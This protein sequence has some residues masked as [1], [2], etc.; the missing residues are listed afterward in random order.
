MDA[1][2]LLIWIVLVFC[3]S[4]LL[5]AR[6]VA[7]GA[8]RGWVAT[9]A[10][11]GLIMGMLVWL[12]PGSAG[13]VG[14]VLWALFVAA[15]SLL[16][17]RVAQ[18]ALRQDYERA[19]LL[20]RGVAFFHPGDG[21]PQQVRLMDAL[22]KARAG[23][24]DEGLAELNEIAL[25]STRVAR[26]ARMQRWRL[27]A[28]WEE[29][30]REVQTWT[31]RHDPGS[32]LFLLR[33]FGETGELERMLWTYAT[34]RDWLESRAEVRHYARLVLD[35]FYGDEARVEAALKGELRM[36]PEG[37]KRYWRATAGQ[38][39]G[40]PSATEELRELTGAFDPALRLA[41]QSRL[42]A[43]AA[44]TAS[45][46]SPGATKLYG[47]IVRS[48]PAGGWRSAFRPIPALTVGLITLNLT[49]FGFEQHLGG[50][51][52]ARVLFAMGAV[53]PEAIFAGQ[54]WR[55][56]SAMWLHFG[57]LHLF[58][59]MT[60]LFIIGPMVE[61]KLGTRKMAAVYLAAGSGSMLWAAMAAR[62]FDTGGSLIVGASGSIMGLVGAMAVLVW[63]SWRRTGSRLARQQFG[64]MLLV[65]GLQTTFDLV[66]P[67]VSMAAHLSGV[68]V[69]IG[70]TWVLQGARPRADAGAALTR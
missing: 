61:S 55:V 58:M 68:I 12:A 52:N 33:A 63:G 51:E 35:A 67:N 60:A 18:A 29:A 44:A 46:L 45:A 48:E 50:A 15:P 47:E 69:G 49:V 3:A 22:G 30:V 25:G 32:V 31:G 26:A 36:L 19:A 28:Q 11:L 27:Q 56:F 38:A 4:V 1:N 13:Y 16:T 62:I 9:V 40:R 14:G 43:D 17:R 70:M 7:A 64:S 23:R 24:W 41:A 34:H 39:A 5:R 53:L 59:N 8:G 57:A 65:I 21:W 6:Q 2:Y 54:W 10:I 42:S 66:T 20:A 37:M